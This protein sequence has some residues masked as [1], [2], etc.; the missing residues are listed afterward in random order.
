MAKEL[1]IELIVDDKGTATIKSFADGTAAHMKQVEGAGTSMGASFV[2]TWQGMAVAAAAAM[3]VMYKAWE[4]AEKAAKFEEMEAGLQG[5]SAQYGM[6]ADSAVEMAK[7]AVGGQLSMMEAGQLA[8]KAFALGFN[9]DQVKQFLVVSERLKDVMGGSIPEAFN[10]ME[11]AAATGRKG[12]L[13]GIGINVDLKKT[14]SDYADAHGIAKESIG[15]H[16]ATLLRANAIMEAA[17]KITD[18]MGEA[19]EST[20]DKM[21]KMRATVADIELMMGQFSIRGGAA[22]IGTMMGVSAAAWAVV[23]GVLKIGEGFTWLISVLPG[24]AASNKELFE[25]MKINADAAWQTSQE[26]AKKGS[27]ALQASFA[28]KKLISLATRKL[29]DAETENF[30]LNKETEKALNDLTV[31]NFNEMVK[32]LTAFEAESY[33]VGKTTEQLE[34]NSLNIRVQKYQ[35]YGADEIR[36]EEL[37]QA[38]LKNIMIRANNE[39]LALLEDLYKATANEKYKI[40]ALGLMKDIKDAEQ[41]KWKNILQSDTDAYILREQKDKEYNEHL[42]GLIGDRVDAEK[43]AATTIIAYDRWA[44]TVTSGGSGS[45]ATGS[46]DKN[47]STGSISTTYNPLD[48]SRLVGYGG[49]FSYGNPLFEK[50]GAFDRGNVIPFARGGIFDSPTIFPMSKG[51]GLMGE[52][53]PEAVMPLTRG[54]DGKLGVKAGGGGATIEFHFHGTL[55]DRKAVNEFAEMIYPQLEKLRQWGH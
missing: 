6:T 15:A 18:Q 16:T 34:I 46:L 19:T 39:H 23:A 52:A 9:P 26:Q 49:Q 2:K 3:G 35:E 33:K 1:K 14:L 7:A 36:L 22:L 45:D 50:G 32:V 12:G 11:K 25:S 17:K 27:D 8:A 29:Q 41:E 38:E 51:M 53:G 55:I 48:P 54:K 24:A 31:K 37:K 21:N 30:R 5:L 43:V 28:E 40:A 20:A 44:D 13:V 42:K 10:A 47:I 4:F